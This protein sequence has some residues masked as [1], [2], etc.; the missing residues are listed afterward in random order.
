MTAPKRKCAFLFAHVV[1]QIIIKEMQANVKDYMGR[2]MVSDLQV[3]RK[4]QGHGG[5][6][7]SVSDEDAA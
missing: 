4:H 2:K 5:N 3:N 7:E 1:P 6:E